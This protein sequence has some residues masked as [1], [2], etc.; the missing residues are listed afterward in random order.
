MKSIEKVIFLKFL[1]QGKM[2]NVN[3]TNLSLSLPVNHEI[4]HGL[5][6]GR[7]LEIGPIFRGRPTDR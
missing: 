3:I 7:V 6:S 1:L 2:V 4:T 5:R